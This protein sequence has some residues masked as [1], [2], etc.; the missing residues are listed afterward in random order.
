LQKIRY[1]QKESLLLPTTQIN[2]I[3][4]ITTINTIETYLN[5]DKLNIL[6]HNY[7]DYNFENI[8][9]KREIL[10]DSLLYFLSQSEKNQYKYLHK[11]KMMQWYESEQQN[12]KDEH[13]EHHPFVNCHYYYLNEIHK[14]YNKPILP[15]LI[16]I[17]E[18]NEDKE[19]NDRK[20]NMKY[21]F[22]FMVK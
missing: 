21:N 22:D 7:Y 19:N 13:D 20:G 6:I 9:E 16:K 1:R 18:N 4:T 12:E 14:G 15:Y 2:K 5:E 11:N 3:E 17:E 10:T 8:L